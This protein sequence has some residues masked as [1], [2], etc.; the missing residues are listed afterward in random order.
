MGNKW[1]YV[2]DNP[3][4]KQ[5]KLLDVARREQGIQRVKSSLDF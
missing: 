3:G 5:K 4:H 1:E 2:K